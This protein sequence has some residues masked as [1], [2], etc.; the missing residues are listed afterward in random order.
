MSSFSESLEE[1]S[2]EDASNQGI[3]DF[4]LTVSCGTNL[5][6]HISPTLT[7]QIQ[8]C[9]VS[10]LTF[11]KLISPS[12][13]L[14]QNLFSQTRTMDTSIQTWAS[15]PP[16]TLS[17]YILQVRNSKF[18]LTWVLHPSRFLSKLPFIWKLLVISYK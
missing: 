12:T 3:D 16:F 10:P 14:F 8:V 9:A 7:R 11:V 18:I 15:S 1:N 13:L 2:S 4:E 5:D 6:P 17:P